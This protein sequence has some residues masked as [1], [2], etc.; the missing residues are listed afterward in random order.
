MSS[1]AQFLP[2]PVLRR[3]L[4]RYP[5]DARY[6]KRARSRVIFSAMLEPLRWFERLRYARKLRNTEIKQPPVFLLGFGRSGTT[7]LHNLMW[8]DPNF[9]VVSNYQ[10]NMHPIALTG[11]RWLPGLFADRMPSKRP[12]DNVAISMDGPQEEEIALVNSTE[13]AALHFMSFPRELPNIYDRYVCDLGTDETRAEA[14]KAAYLEVLKKATILSGDRQLVL[15]TPPN[16]GRVRVLLEMFPDAR[17][18][19]IVRNPYRVYQ[20]MRNMYRK[21]LP[22]QVLQEFDWADIDSWIVEAYRSL[23]SKYLDERKLIPPENLVEIRY[24][25][26]DEHPLEMLGSVYGGLRIGDFESMQPKVEQYLAELGTYEKNRF[27]FP[28]DVVHTVNRNWGFAFEAFGYER[29]EPTES[30]K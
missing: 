10:A 9:G 2:L 13:H 1:I 16:T 23:M 14:W 29:Q 3:L 8:L 22:S 24:E 27:E 7:H 26:L 5:P 4:R 11:R 6:R 17:F 28:A 15:K 21:I 18:V 30:P 12:M 19:H 25:D 20:S